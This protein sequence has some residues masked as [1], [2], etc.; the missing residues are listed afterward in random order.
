M[1]KIKSKP[2]LPKGRI[3][4][5]VTEKEDANTLH[6]L[7]CFHY[8][9]TDKNFGLRCCEKDE[10][11]SFISKLYELSQLTWNQIINTN[12]HKLGLEKVPYNII[13]GKKPNDITED[14]TFIAIRFNSLA[15][16]VG[17]RF[18]RTFHIIWLDPKMKLYNHGK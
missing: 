16:M 12:R 7:F 11:I 9:E 3:K 15:P 8:L 2:R 13:N 10:K 5:R 4:E 18:E 17:Y 6:P 14:Q 1:A